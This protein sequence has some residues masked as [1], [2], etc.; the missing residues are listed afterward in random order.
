MSPSLRHQFWRER[1]LSNNWQSSQN[2]HVLNCQRGLPIRILSSLV[3]RSSRNSG[4]ICYASWRNCI[5][6]PHRLFSE[7]LASQISAESSPAPC[8]EPPPPTRPI[9][10][11]WS[12]VTCPLLH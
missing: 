10:A 2:M 11:P 1:N 7:R 9:E 12:K 6:K 4:R 8:T 5:L 3:A